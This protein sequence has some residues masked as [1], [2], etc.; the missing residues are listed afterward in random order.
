M[1]ARANANRKSDGL[2][3]I[4]PHVTKVPPLTG[5]QILRQTIRYYNGGNE[6]HFNADYI[7]TGNGLDVSV[8]GTR[9]W[10]GSPPG[11]WRRHWANL[12]VRTPWD[13]GP[14]PNYVTNVMTCNS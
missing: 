9:T 7:L 11:T 14:N 6:Y 3:P 1:L 4:H 5:T 12:K 10:A 8:V 13:P 2:P